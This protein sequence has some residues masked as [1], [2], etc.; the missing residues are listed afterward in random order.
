MSTFTIITLE[1]K[2]AAWLEWR[3]GGVTASEIHQLKNPQSQSFINSLKEKLGYINPI[4]P[5]KE[6]KSFEET[7]KNFAHMK[8]ISSNGEY[9]ER[10]LSKAVFDKTGI[11]GKP[12]CLEFNKNP[13]FRASLDFFDEIYGPMEF[14]FT[15]DFSKFKK[16]RDGSTRANSINPYI[17]PD[18]LSQINWIMHLTGYPELCMGMVYENETGDLEISFRYFKKDPALVKELVKSAERFLVFLNNRNIPGIG[19]IQKIAQVS[20]IEGGLHA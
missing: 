9:G 2:S 1:Q 14:K 17:S 3:R 4:D 12:I 16:F 20:V 18:Y 10:V 5:L 11:W 13:Q 6:P 7:Q 15:K 19:R 8:T